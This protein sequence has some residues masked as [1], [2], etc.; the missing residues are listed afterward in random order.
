[1]MRLV[2]VIWIPLLASGGDRRE[3]R[4]AR[5]VGARLAHGHAPP[6]QCFV[7]N[8]HRPSVG[9]KRRVRCA[10]GPDSF[11]GRAGADAG[12]I[13]AARAALLPD[14]GAG[15]VGVALPGAPRGGAAPDH[16]WDLRTVP[17]HR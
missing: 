10:R 1:M 7:R 3:L 2:V 15:A 12:A 14:G 4:P 6:A 13:A 16:G 9:A 5:N 8:A 17:R 11:A